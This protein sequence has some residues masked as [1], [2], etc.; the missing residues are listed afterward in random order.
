MVI[1]YKTYLGCTTIAAGQIM[2][3]CKFPSD[4][5]WNAMPNAIDVPDITLC[6]F[7]KELHD[8]IGVNSDGGATI[9]QANKAF[10]S[11]GYKTSVISHDLSKVLA[12]L[13]KKIPVYMRGTDNAL[14]EGHAW[15]CDGY[16]RS[17]PYDE[18]IL[19]VIETEDECAIGFSTEQEYKSYSQTPG[20]IYTHM[21][22]GWYGDKNAY[23]WD[24][25]IKTANG[26]Y[27]TN[28]KDIIVTY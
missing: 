12:S 7:L 9:D 14:G 24:S 13:E 15:V 25:N 8:K 22:W 6:S 5:D 3:Y 18:Y 17:E 23:F 28:R 19:C 1:R 11:Y 26:N 2:K 16:K 4:I 21:N 10:K 20:L 27:S